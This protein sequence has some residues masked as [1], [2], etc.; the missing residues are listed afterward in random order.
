MVASFEFTLPY[1]LQYSQR[2]SLPNKIRKGQP[3]VDDSSLNDVADRVHPWRICPLGSHYV[4]EHQRKTEHGSCTVSACCR[5]NSS[6]KDAI[7]ADEAKEIARRNSAAATPKP[8]SANWGNP[9]HSQYDN[10][11][12]VW[13][14]Y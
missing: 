9:D 5:K 14:K 7:F 8:C 1:F 2:Y 13:T 12:A 6:K 10:I 4:R 3:T 11:I